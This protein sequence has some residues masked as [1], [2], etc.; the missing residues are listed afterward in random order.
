MACIPFSIILA[1]RV[2]T[3]QIFFGD[4]LHSIYDWKRG[5]VSVAPLHIPRHQAAAIAAFAQEILELDDAALLARTSTS[6]HAEVEDFVPT[7]R[8]V[9]EYACRRGWKDSWP[10]EGQQA[11]DVGGCVCACVAQVHHALSAP[12]PFV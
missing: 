4:G 10:G 2:L 12:F 1:A 3:Q 7:T 11:V 9:L 6:P 5:E 8:A